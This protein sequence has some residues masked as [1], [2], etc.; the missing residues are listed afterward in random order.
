M[1]VRELALFLVDGV[2]GYVCARILL[3]ILDVKALQDLGFGGHL[4]TRGV[5]V[6]GAVRLVRRTRGVDHCGMSLVGQGVNRAG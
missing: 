6:C 5:V 4:E 1:V 3:G 2:S